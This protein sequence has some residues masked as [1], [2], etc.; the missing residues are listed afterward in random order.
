MT[1]S[2]TLLFVYYVHFYID[3]F[4]NNYGKLQTLYAFSFEAWAKSIFIVDS[5]L[6]DFNQISITTSSPKVPNIIS[7]IGI[8]TPYNIN[9]TG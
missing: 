9:R 2:E 4:V 1:P 5:I 7:Y 8:N 6:W 3:I